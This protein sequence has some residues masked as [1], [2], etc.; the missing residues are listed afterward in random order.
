MVSSFFLRAAGVSAVAILLAN[1]ASEPSRTVRGPMSA[2]NAREIGAFSDKRKYGTASPRVVNYGSTVPKGGGR[3]HI[4]R[5]YR[6]AG[7][8]YTPRDNPNYSAV[9]MSSWYGDAFHGRKTANGEVYDKYAYT[10]AHPTMPLPSYARVTNQSNGRSIIVRVNDRGPFHGGRIIDVSERVAN[11][12][13]FKHLGTARVKVDYV[14]RASVSGSDD[15]KL[16]ATLRTDGGAANLSGGSA[17]IMV[18]ENTAVPGL[19]ATPVPVMRPVP[20]ASPAPVV[21]PVQAASVQAPRQEAAVADRENVD[22]VLTESKPVRRSVPLPPDRPFDLDSVPGGG[23][24]IARVNNGQPTPVRAVQTSNRVAGDRVAAIYFAP[25]QGLNGSFAGADPMRRLKSGSFENTATKPVARSG[26][27]LQAGL[28]RDR[29]NAERLTA[30]L[31][32]H[33]NAQSQIVSMNGATFYR[34]TA[35][36]FTS[37]NTARSALAAALASGAAG[38]RLTTN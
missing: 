6:V 4:G 21:T 10:A 34:V 26:S 29:A 11:A 1:C 13:E 32:K 30:V 37:E 33:G 2:Q 22:S 3:D 7:R 35:N 12:L 28:F 9:G 18:A 25:T 23:Q 14:Q 27:V 31:Q 36:D 16:V 15:R 17:P 38:A 24:P 5:P 8:T 19:A 20:V